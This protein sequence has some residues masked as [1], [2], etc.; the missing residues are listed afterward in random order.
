MIPRL[1]PRRSRRE[2]E[3]AIT[4][5]GT[6]DVSPSSSS[7]S[8][9]SVPLEGPSRR[10]FASVPPERPQPPAQH[11]RVVLS[12]KASS[13]NAPPLSPSPSFLDTAHHLEQPN[14]MKSPVA[15]DILC[16]DFLFSNHSNHHSSIGGGG[17]CSSTLTPPAPPFRQLVV[18]AKRLGQDV[19]RK[20]S[21]KRRRRRRPLSGVED[22][23]YDNN[24]YSSSSDEEMSQ[25]RA[26]LPFLFGQQPEILTPLEKTRH[27]WEWCY[28]KVED[29][30]QLSA[31]M[32]M[33]ASTP[34]WSAK[35]APPAKGW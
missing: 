21:S 23:E 31:A 30:Q 27:Y 6:T 1:A 2:E 29:P 9:L 14:M 20:H 17:S 18:S 26:G 4:F 3:N 35:R 22:E 8:S 11:Q 34:S 15:S 24:Y 16:S 32:A 28:G 13:I 7:S 25:A 12:D 5:F 10:F 33:T 19:R